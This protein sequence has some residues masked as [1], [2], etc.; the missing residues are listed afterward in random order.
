MASVDPRV[1]LFVP[2]LNEIEGMKVTLPHIRPEWCDQILIADGGSSDGSL[3]YAQQLG[4]ETYVQ[5]RK[6]IRFAYM[7]AWP[8]IRGDVVITFSP[9]GNCP[10]EGIPRLVA[11]MNDGYDMVIASRYLGDA[12]S[13]DDD[14]LTGFGNWLFTTLINTL[15]GGHYTDA[16]G[17]FRAYRTDLFSRLGLDKEEGYA[18]ERLLGTRIG[19][20]PLLSIRCAKRKLRVSEIP[21]PE[22]ARIGGERKLQM[23]RWGGAYMLQ[24]FRETY[25]SR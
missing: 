7:E 4:L 2:V 24:V 14:M 16:M 21:C 20:E 15:H 3:E 12:S 18:P 23:F 13:D 6:G 17:I 10:I 1:T 25:H 9:D 8:L 11:M 19:I 5:R 22:P